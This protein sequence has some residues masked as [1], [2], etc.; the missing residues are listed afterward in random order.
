M[1]APSRGGDRLCHRTPVLHL[2]C[3][4]CVCVRRVLLTALRRG[5]IPRLHSRC[6]CE[7][8]GVESGNE[9]TEE[10]DYNSPTSCVII[11][12]CHGNGLL[13]ELS[14]NFI[15]ARLARQQRI[16]DYRSHFSI[17]TGKQA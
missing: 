3:R 8:A 17:L 5:L 7:Y 15:P 13:T 9:V 12:C 14:G 1:S 10:V 16:M 11:L 4:M 2:L 6:A